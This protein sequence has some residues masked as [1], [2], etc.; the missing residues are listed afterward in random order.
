VSA[1]LPKRFA[2]A[3]LSR[4]TALKH[5]LKTCMNNWDT[6][7]PPPLS[8]LN[9]LNHDF[10]EGDGIDFEPFESF[11]SDKETSDWFKAWT[12][13]EEVDGGEFRIFGQDGTGGYAAFWLRDPSKPLLEQPIVFLGSE[14]EIGVVA[15][16][17]QHYIWLLAS[18]IGPFEAVEF[19]TIARDPNQLFITFAKEYS[20]STLLNREEVLAAANS[21]NSEFEEKIQSLCR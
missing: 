3:D 13:N 19:P 5:V 17:F 6:T 9:K 15:V 7:L 16:N 20:P 21:L 10:A 2:A 11:L 8:K 18:G 12:G 1:H 4:Y 14:G